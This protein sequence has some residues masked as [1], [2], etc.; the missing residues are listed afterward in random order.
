MITGSKYYYWRERFI[1]T[2]SLRAFDLMTKHYQ[3]GD[4]ATLNMP[5]GR[6]VKR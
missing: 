4:F 2:G 5:V 1:R 3:A 6:R